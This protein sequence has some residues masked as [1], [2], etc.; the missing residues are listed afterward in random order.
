MQLFTAQ[1]NTDLLSLFGEQV[2]FTKLGQ[3]PRP[4]TAVVNHINESASPLTGGVAV[5]TLSLVCLT[6]DLP[7]IDTVGWLAAV[8]GTVYPV[9]DLI[10]NY[11]MSELTEVKLAC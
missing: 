3:T 5:Q 8:R 9:I 10:S 2:T 6:S 7:G 1:D 4:V 11:V